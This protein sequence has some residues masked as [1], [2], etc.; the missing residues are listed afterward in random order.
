MEVGVIPKLLRPL[1][2]LHDRIKLYV[3]HLYTLQTLKSV[4]IV[5]P[6]SEKN[7]S[8][9]LFFYTDGCSNIKKN[10]FRWQNKTGDSWIYMRTMYEDSSYIKLRL[11][12]KHS[13]TS[14]HA[15]PC[16]HVREPE[17]WIRGNV[18]RDKNIEKEG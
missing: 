16:L 17:I 10:I 15:K 5:S 1:I 11:T 14:E 7:T 9:L 4:F 3:D 2:S 18:I 8:F 6:N 13:E 12:L